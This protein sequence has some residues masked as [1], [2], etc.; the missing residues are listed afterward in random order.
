MKIEIEEWRERWER[1]GN[2]EN[3]GKELRRREEGEVERTGYGEGGGWR[4]GV[5]SAR[6]NNE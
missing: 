1:R 6:E 2:A 3:G 4:E 5:E